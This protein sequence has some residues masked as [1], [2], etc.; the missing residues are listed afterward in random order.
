MNTLF[1]D[2]ERF[3]RFE[4]HARKIIE[5][6]RRTAT[7]VPGFSEQPVTVYVPGGDDKYPSFWVRDAVMQCRS[8]L[9]DAATMETMLRVILTFQNGPQRRGLAHGLRIDPWAIPDHINLPGIGDEPFQRKY[10]PGAVFYPG[11]YSPSD[12]QGNG[13]FG[14]RPA[15]DDLYEVVELAR[16]VVAQTVELE[17]GQ[18]HQI[19]EAW[20]LKPLQPPQPVE[21]LARPIRGD[22][23]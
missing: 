22:R 19:C 17:I 16:L 20:V 15:D 13:R 3:T 6:C 7:S 10:Q 12:D 11:T 21:F 18:A 14:L 8:G 4:A 2:P 9:V 23:G 1:P 5:R